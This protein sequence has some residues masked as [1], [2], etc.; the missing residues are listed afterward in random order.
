MNLA[1]T[2][3]NYE[4]IRRGLLKMPLMKQYG[5][6][7]YCNVCTKD[8]EKTGKSESPGDNAEGNVYLDFVI[9]K[10]EEVIQVVQFG[11]SDE[12][13]KGMPVFYMD[14]EDDWIEDR[15]SGIGEVMAHRLKSKQTPRYRIPEGM[16]AETIK[17]KK[18][19]WKCVASR[20][21]LEERIKRMERGLPGDD[22]HIVRFLKGWM[23]M[24]IGHYLKEEP[25]LL[26]ELE[27]ELFG[28][29]NEEVDK[30]PY[31]KVARMI[32][33]LVIESQCISDDTGA[34][35]DY[36]KGLRLMR[37]L[38]EP[39]CKSQKIFLKEVSKS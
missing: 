32:E 35:L 30:T 1:Q 39:I 33:E 24:P 37:I 7:L 23:E 26:E 34:D 31:W 3:M 36:E 8:L 12:S 25:E 29:C 13:V 9:C 6:N 38:A 5:L 4:R 16:K 19:L 28:S 17:R 21:P 18:G 10:E 15:I 27:Q 14:E 11:R 22:A 20:I 2:M